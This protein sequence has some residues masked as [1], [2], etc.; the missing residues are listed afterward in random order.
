MLTHKEKK[1][2]IQQT[3]MPSEEQDMIINVSQKITDTLYSVQL[4]HD[5]S[6]EALARMVEVYSKCNFPRVL[7]EKI[8]RASCRERV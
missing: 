6:D 1:L 8:G 7:E 5:I 2:I 4:R 3:D